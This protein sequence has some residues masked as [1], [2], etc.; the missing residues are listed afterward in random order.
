MSAIIP[1]RNVLDLDLNNIDFQW[2]MWTDAN[3]SLATICSPVFI[4]FVIHEFALQRRK[5][6]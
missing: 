1:V 5:R 6:Q 3:G 2:I 4:V